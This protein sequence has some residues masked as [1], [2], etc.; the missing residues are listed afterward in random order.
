M[1]ITLTNPATVAVNGVTAESDAN[2][3]VTYLELLYP[4]SLRIFVSYGT[5]TGQVFAPGTVLP[6]VIITISLHDGTWSSSNG[7]SGTLS[8][9][10]LSNMQAEALNIRN[11][12]ESLIAS[13]ITPGTFV[14]W[15]T[16]M[17]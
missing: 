17:F 6:K 9:A 16:G 4:F 15:T 5:T 14:A 8:P 12:L 7:L 2:T 1:S 3:A 13:G 10:Q 11:G